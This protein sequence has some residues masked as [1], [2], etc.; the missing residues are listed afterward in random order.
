MQTQS[1]RTNGVTHAW[2]LS[3]TGLIL[4]K[5]HESKNIVT[6]SRVNTH[7]QHMHTHN[8]CTHTPYAPT[9]WGTHTYMHLHEHAHKHTCTRSPAMKVGSRTREA[10]ASS[11]PAAQWEH[12][13][14]CVQ[15]LDLGAMLTHPDH[16]LFLSLPISWTWFLNPWGKNRLSSLTQCLLLNN[17]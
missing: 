9:H 5:I 15:R 10:S 12:T 14:I 16:L 6:R 2:E 7:T 3:A 13:Q 11:L 4:A 1:P 17:Y 8:I